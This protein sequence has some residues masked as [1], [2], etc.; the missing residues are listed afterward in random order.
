MQ[1][2]MRDFEDWL[3]D[4]EDMPEA[5]EQEHEKAVAKLEEIL[6]YEDALVSTM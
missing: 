2:T 5:L 1:G 3:D 6:P 4:D